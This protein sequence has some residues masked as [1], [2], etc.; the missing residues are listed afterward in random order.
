M[1]LTFGASYTTNAGTARSQG[2]ELSGVWLPAENWRLTGSYAL[3]DAKLTSDIPG[4]VEGQTAFGRSGDRLPYSA[5]QS[6]AASVT[7]YF[8]L[9]DGRDWFVGASANL[10]GSRDMEFVQSSTVP[11]IHLPGYATYAL[12][13]GMHGTNWTLTFFVRNLTDERAYLNASRRAPSLSSGTTAT[14]SGPLIQPR[15]VGATLSWDL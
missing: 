15:T 10:V 7:R 1:D 4:F 14:L 8:Q 5:R 9:A 3:N 12:N 2:I 6:F 13:A 11:R